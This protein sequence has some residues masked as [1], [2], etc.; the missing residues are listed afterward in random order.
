LEYSE[1]QSEAINAAEGPVMVISCAGSGKTS[2]ILE[3]TKKIAA[4]GIPAE[5]ILVVTFSKPAALEMRERFAQLYQAGGRVKFATIHSVCYSI[6]AKAYSLTPSAVLKASEKS[7]FLHEEYIRLKRTYGNDFSGGYK[8]IGDFIRNIVLKISGYMTLLYKEPSSKADDIISD[9]YEKEIFFDYLKFKKISGKIDYDDMIIECHKYLKARK[10]ALSYW[11]RIFRYIMIDEYQ[12]TT[13]LQAEIFFMLTLEK[14][15]CV[16]GDDDQSIY[17][18]RDADSGIFNRFLTEYPDAKQIFLETNYRSR[19]QIIQAAAKLIRHNENRFKKEFKAF[20]SGT[21]KIE[22]IEVDDSMQQTDEVV[23]RI[24][25]YEQRKIPLHSTAVL[26]RIRSAAAVLCSRLMSEDIPFYTKELP[27]DIHRSLVY[28][29]LKA[30]YRLANNLSGRTDLRR[31]INRPKRFIKA[32][33]V[34]NCGLDKQA[35]IRR[36]TQNIYDG[37]R[38]EKI[39]DAIDLLFADLKHLKGKSPAEFMQYLLEDMQ[40]RDSLIE[41]AEFLN[42]NSD[43]FTSEFDALMLEAKKFGSMSEWDRYA[44]EYRNELIRF[45]DKSRE[46]GVYLSTFH[47]AK[48]LEWDNVIIISANERIT[49]LE[50][51]GVIENPEEERRLFYVAVTRA[52][53]ELTIVHIKD[54]KGVLPSR[55]IAEMQTG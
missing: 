32:A 31:I 3:R 45:M 39:I 21:A 51:N 6:L 11:Q 44:Q 47:S 53:E 4:S 24:R 1:K 9:K 49:P 26:Y 23:K 38:K 35:L 42:I 14:N 46:N 28:Q 37:E 25:Q 19:P 16:V 30:Y 41:Y 52:K 43:A 8:D 34:A 48:G 50:R 18:F 7:T 17:S 55:Y 36:C 2:V 54:G 27:E 12:D 40:Y 10:D 5:N 20:N 13:I 22:N 29:D 15:I 33:A